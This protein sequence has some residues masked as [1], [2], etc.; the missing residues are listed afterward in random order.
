MGVFGIFCLTKSICYR[1]RLKDI[2]ICFIVLVASSTAAASPWAR[3]DNELFVIS[4]ADYF[5]AD[6]GPVNTINGIVDSRFERLMSNTYVEYGLT[7]NITIGGKALYGTSWLTRGRDTETASG[8]SEVEA[9]IQHQAF[10]SSTHAGAVR[11]AAARPANFSSGARPELQSNGVDMDV[12]ALYGRNMITTPVKIFTTTEIGYR[13]RFGG[14]AD[15]IRMDATI[16][17]EPSDRFLVLFDFFST[18]SMQNENIGGAD[19]DIV[20]IQPSLLW[21]ATKRWAFQA[22]MTEEVASRNISTG[23]TYFFGLWSRF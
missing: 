21:R 6:L 5:K 12:S 2:F 9:Y 19:F 16:G 3:A 20:K 4:R 11:L 23:R 22:G 8:F 10:R 15:H 13:K 7:D 18:I 17:F 14:A 1:L